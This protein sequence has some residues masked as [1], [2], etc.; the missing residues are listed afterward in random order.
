MER[1]LQA[2]RYNLSIA[3]DSIS[4]PSSMIRDSFNVASLSDANTHEKLS[5]FRSLNTSHLSFKR[6]LSQGVITFEYC[7]HRFDFMDTARFR[8]APKLLE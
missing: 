4:L 5:E 3:A 8:F 7:A 6:A 2:V 1:K